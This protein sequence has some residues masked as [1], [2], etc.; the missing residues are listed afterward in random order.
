[1][2]LT[3]KQIE[4]FVKSPD[5]KARVILIYGPDSG[6]VTE[7]SKTISKTVVTDLNDPFNV[8]TFT[9]EKILSDPALFHDEA[10]AQSLMGGNRLIIIKNGTDSINVILKDYLETP[11]QETLIVVEADNLSPRSALR[12]LCETAKNAA[13]VPCY[14]DD[15]RNLAGII[16][17][18]CTHAGYT[19]QPDAVIAFSGAIVGDRTI[20]RNE[21]E[22]LLLFKGLRKGY[23]GFQ[24]DPVHERIGQIT[25]ND[26][27]ASCGDVRDWSMDKLVYAIGDGDVHQTY[28]IIKSLFKDQIAPIVLLR[29]SQA[30]FWRLLSVKTKIKDGMKHPDALKTLNPP[31]FWKVQDDFQRQLNKWDI[32]PL[33]MALDA[34]NKCEANSKK[35][36]YI[37]SALVENTLIQ[38]ARYNPRRTEHAA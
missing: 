8:I 30:H 25:I 10:N 28:S 7:R 19:I 14:V 36:G 1:M 22:K 33:E 26:I 5:P 23:L 20:A 29:A 34:L 6:L 9:S 16:R 15:E 11:S 2:K 13:A 4:P 38:L 27:Y 35:T 32:T 24:G 31:L 3:F 17:D 18:M 37:D 21:I 12:K